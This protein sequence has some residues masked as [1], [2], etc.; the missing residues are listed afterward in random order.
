MLLLLLLLECWRR[1]ARRLLS[2]L[3]FLMAGVDAQEPL[4]PMCGFLHRTLNKPLKTVH[5]RLNFWVMLG[6]EEECLSTGSD[7]MFWRT[8]LRQVIADARI[9]VQSVEQE[10]A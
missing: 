6:I 5:I 1:K 8:F 7:R 4:I 10:N 9:P 3:E 2:L